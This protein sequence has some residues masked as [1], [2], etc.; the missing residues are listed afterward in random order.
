MITIIPV[1]MSSA[2]HIDI[3]STAGSAS[4]NAK[5][6][7]RLIKTHGRLEEGHRYSKGKGDTYLKPG[8]AIPMTENPKQ[9]HP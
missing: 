6:T 4:L 9:T 2:L 3:A 5:M 8:D 1:C 7:R